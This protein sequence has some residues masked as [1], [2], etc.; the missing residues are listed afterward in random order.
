MWRWLISRLP[1]LEKG[2]SLDLNSTIFSRHG[3]PISG[4][5]PS[6]EAAKLAIRKSGVDPW[7]AWISAVRAG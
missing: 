7:A 6:V 3:A 2:F 5:L 1:Q 4:P